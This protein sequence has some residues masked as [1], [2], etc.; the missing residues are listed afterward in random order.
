MRD[1]RPSAMILSLSSGI[2]FWPSI[3]TIC[4]PVLISSA[5]ASFP[6]WEPFPDSYF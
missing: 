1:Q 3:K 2:E 4:R 5:F 6:K